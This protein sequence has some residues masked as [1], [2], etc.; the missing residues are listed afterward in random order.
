MTFAFCIPLVVVA[1]M[2]YMPGG[3]L[4]SIL[5]S[6][7]VVVVS[8]FTFSPSML[9]MMMVAGSF[10]AADIIRV[11]ALWVGFGKIVRVGVV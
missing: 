3:S 5:V 9:V 6:V 11:K 10:C 1:L 8:S 7:L 2:R 4:S